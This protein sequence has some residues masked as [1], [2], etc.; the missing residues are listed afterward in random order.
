M[1][2][3]IQQNITFV[4]TRDLGRSADFYERSLGLRLA[5]DQGHCRIY[6]LSGNSYLGVCDAPRRPV[7]SEGV[8]VTLV[9]DDVDGWC[10]H[11]RA[12]GVPLEKE[13]ADNPPYRIYNAFLRDPNGYLIEIQRFWEPL[14]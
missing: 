4:Y 13:P 7:V 6:H 3:A 11:L 1:P 10:A 5:R 9:T 12:R 2:P 14:Q 8:V